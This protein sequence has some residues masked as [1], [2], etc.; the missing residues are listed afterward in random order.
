M[1]PTQP[2]YALA[3]TSFRFPALAALA[4]RAPLGGHREV[5]LATYLGARLVHDTLPDRGISPAVRAERALGARTWLSTLALP[6]AVR[7]ALARLVESSLG[8]PESAG[9]AV[10]NVSAVTANYLDSGARSEL[11]HLAASLGAK[12]GIAQDP[13]KR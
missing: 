1:H 13:G 5:A 8:S 2:P 12:P 10:Q 9:Q 6:A 3:M 7:P 4:G 11:E